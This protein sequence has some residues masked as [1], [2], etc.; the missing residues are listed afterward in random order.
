MSLL[1]RFSE[2]VQRPPDDADAVAL[3]SEERRAWLWEQLTS[4]KNLG[5]AFWITQAVG[6]VGLACGVY[7]TSKF[8][9]RY[10]DKRA[11]RWI[12][13]YLDAADYVS[14]PLIRDTQ[15]AISFRADRADAP[16]IIATKP[17]THRLPTPS[18]RRA[19][20]FSQIL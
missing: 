17:R 2:L 5:I 14:R 18:S 9:D 4:S 8:W 7:L 1:V 19:V 3:T 12:D 10:V 13:R 6:L 11:G 20:T 15:Q 16:T